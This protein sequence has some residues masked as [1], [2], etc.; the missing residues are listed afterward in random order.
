M[1]QAPRHRTGVRLAQIGIGLMLV[2]RTTTEFRCAPYF[3]GPHGVGHGFEAATFG[4]LLGGPMDHAF[5]TLAGTYALVLLWMASAW[6]LVLGWQTRVATALA[7]LCCVVFEVRL[8]E[9]LDGGDNITR[10][11]LGYML[12]LLPAERKYKPNSLTVF[13][14]N[15]AV[16]AIGAQLCIVYLTAG[17]IKVTGKRWWQGTALYLISQVEWFSLPVLRPVF[18]NPFVTTLGCLTTVLYQLTFPLA[19]LTRFRLIW[20]AIGIGL[21][22]GIAVAMG[23]YPFSTVMIGFELFLVSDQQW[24]RARRV[25]AAAWRLLANRAKPKLLS[26][27]TLRWS[28]GGRKALP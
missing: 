18:R 20:L 15:C 3:W 17:F 26:P 1:N 8:P 13:V 14:H 24:E 7:L 6:L 2:F 19:I 27:A 12:F 21:H 4:H 9:L 11:M 5:Q 22:V 28:D 25:G 23:L 10:I 16:L